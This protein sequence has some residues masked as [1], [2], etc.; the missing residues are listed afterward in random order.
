MIWQ[1][2][3]KSAHQKT[4]LTINVK[5]KLYFCANVV[6]FGSYGKFVDRNSLRQKQKHSVR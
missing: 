5:S 2:Q 4:F 3:L 1:Q 6:N